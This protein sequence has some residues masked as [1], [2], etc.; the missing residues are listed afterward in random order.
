MAINFAELEGVPQDQRQSV[1]QEAVRTV[2]GTHG[3]MS[4]ASHYIGCAMAAAV[5]LPLA[6][7]DR[8]PL[9]AVPAGVSAYAVCLLVGMALWRRSMTRELRVVISRIVAGRGHKGT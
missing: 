5:I 3:K 9:V 7:M 8:G 2:N 4:R 6:A 1:M